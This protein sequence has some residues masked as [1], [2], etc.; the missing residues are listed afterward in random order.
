MPSARAIAALLPLQQINFVYVDRLLVAEEGDQ[1]AEADGSFRGGIGDDKDGKDLSVKAV[2]T[3]ESHQVQV[4]GVQDQFDR[5][6]DDDHIT[7]SEHTD[8]AQD[9][10]GRGYDQVMDSGNGSHWTSSQFSVKAGAR[11]WNGA[12]STVLIITFIPFSRPFGASRSLPFFPTACAA[13]LNSYA[14]SRRDGRA[15]STV[16]AKFF[17]WPSPRR[18]SW[19]PATIKTL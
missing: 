8:D 10:Q 17:S 11:S 1:D 2:E 6:Q 13:G 3:R 15:S 5:H 4:D 16:T 12:T 18:R 14:A 19:R 9:E 7:A